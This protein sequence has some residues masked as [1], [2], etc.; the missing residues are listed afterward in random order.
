M[1][2]KRFDALARGLGAQRSRRDAVKGIAAGLFGLGAA[3]AA[4]RG[5]AAQV[6]ADRATCDDP[7]AFDSDCNA[8]LRCRNGR[9]TPIKDSERRCSGSIQCPRFFEICQNGRCVNQ[10]TCEEN[11]CRR[12]AQCRRDEVCRNG[13]CEGGSGTCRRNSDCRRD[14]VCRNNR[15]ER[16]SARCSRNSDCRRNEVCRNDRCV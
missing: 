8:G 1:D 3:G 13:R 2:S 11:R 12:N 9:C 6:D 4:V 5:S 14:E 16:D 7:C 10:T 15:C